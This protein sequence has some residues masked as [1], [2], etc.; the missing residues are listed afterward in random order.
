MRK[1]IVDSTGNRI[2]MISFSLA[3]YV[4]F[5]SSAQRPAYHT[6]R[7]EFCENEWLGN[8][9]TTEF[10]DNCAFH[11]V[12]AHCLADLNWLEQEVRALRCEL[13]SITIYSK[14]GV[15][16]T[17]AIG[18]VL[19]TKVRYVRLDNMGRCDHTYGY[20]MAQVALTRQ[21]KSDEVVVFLKDT[22][23][24]H[25]P[26]YRR[27]LREM[28][29]IA[30]G[31]ARFSCGM[32][33]RAT[34]GFKYSNISIWHRTDVLSKFR[35]QHYHDVYEREYRSPGNFRFPDGNFVTW[36]ESLRI[37]LRSS[38][39]T[40]VCYG[41]VFATLG[42]Q[43]TARGHNFWYK[44]AQSLTR[45]DSIEEG[46]FMERLWAHVLLHRT[47]NLSDK[48]VLRHGRKVIWHEHQGLQGT[49]YGCRETNVE[50]L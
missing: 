20:H 35:L 30:R 42:A 5:F 46:H 9:A 38:V 21:V 41:G 15:N 3:M 26:G 28:I 34:A 37:D 7:T 22:R 31:S 50:S 39:V 23:V 49:L 44:I 13:K 24:I 18:R 29:D 36:S 4:V 1:G 32:V 43:I 14:C 10:P 40:P 47:E 19:S 48:R 6:R 2:R 16:P 27:G 25:Q 45:G 33:P 11:V 17:H 8:F 12:V